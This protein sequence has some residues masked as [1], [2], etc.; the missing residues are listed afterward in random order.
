MKRTPRIYLDNASTT[1]VS[2]EVAEAMVP[3]MDRFFGNPS[4]LHEP[5]REARRA[6]EYSRD[7]VA[8]AVGADPSEITFSSGGTESNNMAVFGALLA[9]PKKRHIVTTVVE[10]HAILHAVDFAEQL[11]FAVTRVPVNENGFVNPTEIESAMRED[12]ALVSV[13]YANNETGAIQ[14]IERIGQLV[15]AR[16]VMMHTDAVQAFGVVDICAKKLPVD[17]LTLSSH[18]LHGPKGVGALYVRQGVRLKPTSFGGAQ[19]R[20]RRAGTENVPGIVGF[21]VAAQIAAAC[22]VGKVAHVR[23]LKQRMKRALLEKMDRIRMNTPEHSLPTI[24]NVAFEGISAETLLMRL[25]MVGIAAS[26]GSA[27]TSGSVQPSHVLIAMGLPIATVKSSV[28][29]SFSNDNTIDEIDVA[30]CALD[31]IIDQLHR[32]RS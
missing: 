5:G 29:F 10:H 7:R 18:K 14:D 25:D 16:D 32:R 22:R 26:S 31:E 6:I 24:L 20:N 2:S 11:G 3:F 15:R 30:V 12:T 8:A 28:R 1:A 13:M 19:E 9:N 4:S 23:C 17:L 21:G 27:C